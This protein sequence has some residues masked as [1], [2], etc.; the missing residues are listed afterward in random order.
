MQIKTVQ[1]DA[2]KLVVPVRKKNHNKNLNKTYW[3][4]YKDIDFLVGVDLRNEN[5]YF[6]P[7]S[8]VEKYKSTISITTIDMFKNNI[9]GAL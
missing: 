2:N 6:I 4:T 5:I 3:Y 1:K 8:Y 7:I 9:I